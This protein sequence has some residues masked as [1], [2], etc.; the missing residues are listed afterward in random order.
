[1]LTCVLGTVQGTKSHPDCYT[2]CITGIS[3]FREVLLSHSKKVL[4]LIPTQAFLWGVCMF[5]MCL[6]GLCPCCVCV[7]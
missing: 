2:V 5:S 6:N 7:R 3:Q 1:M 4:G